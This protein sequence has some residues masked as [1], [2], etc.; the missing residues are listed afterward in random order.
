MSVLFLKGYGDFVADLEAAE[1]FAADF[2]RDETDGFDVAA[3]FVF[4][5][6]G[7][8]GFGAGQAFFL[9]GQ[10]FHCV[11]LVR[12]GLVRLMLVCFAVL[13]KFQI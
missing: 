4:R 11:C 5:H 2:R 13:G 9:R 12:T 8:V 7:K 6:F 10:C 3:G 1:A